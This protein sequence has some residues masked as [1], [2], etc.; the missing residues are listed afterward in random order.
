MLYATKDA[1]MH[2]ELH[3]HL[4]IIIIKHSKRHTKKDKTLSHVKTFL[5]NLLNNIY[6]S[7]T[8]N[9]YQSTIYLHIWYSRYF[10]R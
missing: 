2:T 5:R 4:K 7:S 9:I 8:L 6:G 1:A 10:Y 3:M